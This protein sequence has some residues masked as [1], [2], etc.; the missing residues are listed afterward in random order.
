MDFKSFINV[1][2]TRSVDDRKS[3]S[4]GAFFL[5]KRLVFWTSKKKNCTSQSTAE[6]EYVTTTINYSNVVWFKQQL[7]GM[8]IE[9]KNPIVIYCDNTSAINISKN[10]MI[11]TKTKQITIK[12]HF[13][14]ELVQ[15]KKVTLKYVNTKE[16]ITGIFTKPLPKDAFLY[17]RGKLGSFPYVKLTNNILVIHQLSMLKN[18]YM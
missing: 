12:Y 6:A 1:D 11:H 7:G 5:G 2:W 3:P 4:G 8:K 10:P 17:L 18:D 16:Q 14:R 9:I 15:E 13:L